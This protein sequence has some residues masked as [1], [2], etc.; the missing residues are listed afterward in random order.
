MVVAPTPASLSGRPATTRSSRPSS[1]TGHQG[2]K[3]TLGV[4]RQNSFW[5]LDNGNRVYDPCSVDECPAFELPIGATPVAGTWAGSDATGPLTKPSIGT[6][7]SGSWRLDWNGNKTWQGCS[8]GDKCFTFGQNGDLPVVG[9]FH[10]DGGTDWNGFPGTWDRPEAY[11]DPLGG[12]VYL[13]MNCYARRG[14][15][16]IAS[17][18]DFGSQSSWKVWSLFG[19]YIE[20]ST[21]YMMTSVGGDMLYVLGVRGTSPELTPIQVNTSTN[22]LTILNPWYVFQN[23]G[24]FSTFPDS[25]AWADRST[26]STLAR[27][28]RV[29]ASR[30][31]VGVGRLTGVDH[32]YAIHPGIR[33]STS[34]DQVI[35]LLGIDVT[36][37][38][39][40]P[41]VTTTNL[42][43][44]TNATS[45]G[46]A[47]FG[48][49]VAG[50]PG[51]LRA[52]LYSYNVDT[53]SGQP[54]CTPAAMGACNTYTRWLSI[55]ADPRTLLTAP[56]GV[57]S[58]AP[59]S[60][61][62]PNGAQR[63]WS[64]YGAAGDYIAGASYRRDN[65]ASGVATAAG[66]VMPWTEFTSPSELHTRK[67]D[68]SPAAPFETHAFDQG[69]DRWFTDD[70]DWAA[71]Q[72]KAECSN[73]SVV[74]GVSA[75][76]S[77]SARAH[78]ILCNYELIP[79]SMSGG[80]TLD[81]A[82]GS[83]W[84]D[85]LPDW[86]VGFFK[87]ECGPNDA[88]TGV[89]QTI[90]GR[91]DAVRCTPMGG[92]FHRTT[93]NARVF[94]TGDNRGTTINGDWAN[95]FF[96]GECAGGEIVKGVSAST[97]D[98]SVHA[99]LCCAVSAM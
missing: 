41:A 59:L 33:S 96:K 46:E 99:I 49:L 76:A 77:G 63:V 9:L 84:R 80:Y 4:Y 64:G 38:P 12:R 48:T 61:S 19:R 52:A 40:V 45:S 13:S 11:A 93:C 29:V 32:L 88:V 21:P 78:S 10:W 51:S 98:G 70:G 25:S 66:F 3:S 68:V 1:L 92:N 74:F 83:Q 55:N 20:H 91:V 24:T 86:D 89:A 23:S 79:M 36:I 22:T 14:E 31:L 72:F 82:T 73:S 97:S 16:V 81:F 75:A 90:G 50:P 7:T 42:A 54:T 35:R 34:N 67:R 43:T 39:L 30:G 94:N 95:P 58:P 85:S 5:K 8:G 57:S 65:N 2:R 6:F 44:V 18:N 37:N 17:S 71:N 28:G 87:G 47:G 27:A 60:A 26:T 69:D 56:S 15:A 53:G 62:S